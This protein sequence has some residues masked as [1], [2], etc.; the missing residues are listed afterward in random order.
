MKRFSEQSSNRTSSRPSSGVAE[1]P[2]FKDSNTQGHCLG[3]VIDCFDQT[4]SGKVPAG[5]AE[6]V[7][8]TFSLP[9]HCAVVCE[10]V[11]AS[12]NDDS[13]DD[14][15]IC[16]PP[17]PLPLLCLPPRAAEVSNVP[18]ATVGAASGEAM[19][20]VSALFSLPL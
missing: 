16:A 3:F 13:I 11:V 20:T 14:V 6:R 19:T 12:L 1:C 15:S 7:G 10:V 9:S 17:F 18:T 5:V 8:N 4:R 2:Q